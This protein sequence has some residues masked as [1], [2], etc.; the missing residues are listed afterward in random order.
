M[1]KE[2]CHHTP[3]YHTGCTSPTSP[4][5]YELDMCSYPGGAGSSSASMAE[6]L[7]A[8]VLSYLCLTLVVQILG[9]LLISFVLLLNLSYLYFITTSR[10][11]LQIS[12]CVRRVDGGALW[13]S[14]CHSLLIRCFDERL[15]LVFSQPELTVSV[16]ATSFY[17]S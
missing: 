15:P 12:L 9:A 2:I 4:A 16:T 17:S 7:V 3:Q 6:M 14:S 13:F 8:I 10:G 1:R 11:F 5:L